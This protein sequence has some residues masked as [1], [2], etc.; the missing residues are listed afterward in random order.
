MRGLENRTLALV[1][2]IV[3][4]TSIFLGA[5]STVRADIL[6]VGPDKPYST[7]ASVETLLYIDPSKSEFWTPSYSQVFKV[8]IKI[9]NVTDLTCYEFKL[10]WNTT[11]L[12]FDY[13]FIVEI[14]PLPIIIENIDES[15]GRYWL[16]VSARGE[17]SFTG[18]ATLVELYFKIKHD[19]I[20]PNNAYSLLNLNETVLGD[21][22]EPAPQPIVHMVHDGEYWL[23]STK[24]KM[25]VEPP[26]SAAKKLG[27]VFNVNVT[28]QDVVDLYDFEFWLYYNT[29]LLDM[30]NP[31]VQLGPL[32][33]GA[34]IYIQEW[35]D[36]G[37]Y[38]HFAAKL[39]SPAPPVSGSGTV[40]IVTF[41]ATAASIWP[42][43]NLECTLDLI[44]TKLKT[45]GGL[46]ILHYE[47]D[48]L[49][50]YTPLI[51]DL[52]SD[53]TV[54]LDDLYVIS[55]AFGSK[56]GDSNWNRIADLTRD[57]VVNILDLRTAARHYGEDC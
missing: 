12:D 51:G 43:P 26:T 31:Y 6:E 56:P 41:K 27:K 55:A 29:T 53:G 4:L 17:E 33:S 45:D 16:A 42:D 52:T 44:N 35:D 37:G 34:N 30:W 8:N 48:G 15:Q 39:T 54:D 38:V 46:E 18:G 36:L 40:A 21:A 19:P 11:L 14:W 3:L 9:A 24:P 2:T 57:N 25:K 5:I 20:Y 13:A 1:L 49:Y 22:S 28:V 47:V 23:Y 7:A 10:Y 32:M 50:S